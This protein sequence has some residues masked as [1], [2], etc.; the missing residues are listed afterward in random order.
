MTSFRADASGDPD[1]T[2]GQVRVGI[3]SA[4]NNAREVVTSG[5]VNKVPHADLRAAFRH[6]FRF[7]LDIPPGAIIK[8]GAYI[9]LTASHDKGPAHIPGSGTCM[10]RIQI[11]DASDAAPLGDTEHAITG[12]TYLSRVVDW[13]IE[14]DWGAGDRT[15]AQRA[16]NLSPLLQAIVDR[17]GFR[18]GNHV[19]FMLGAS[20][21][22]G[23]ERAVAAFGHPTHG[24]ATG[25][26]E[27]N[28]EWELRSAADPQPFELAGFGGNVTGGG[29]NPKHTF[30]VR[31]LQDSGEGSFR[32]AVMEA[33]SKAEDETKLISIEVEG[34]IPLKSLIPVSA[35]NITITGRHAPGPFAFVATTGWNNQL[36]TLQGQNQ[37]VEHC[38]FYRGTPSAGNNASA[39]VI[40]GDGV[41]MRFC[42]IAFSNDE[43]VT[44]WGGKNITL[45]YCFMFWPLNK[46]THKEKDKNAQPHGFGPVIGK[47]NGTHDARVTFDKCIMAYLAGERAPRVQQSHVEVKNTVVFHWESD[48][49]ASAWSLG[50]FDDIPIKGNIE[51]CI[52]LQA[53][54]APKDS[55]P[56]AIR[57]RSDPAHARKFHISKD[58]VWQK[59]NG[60]RVKAWFLLSGGKRS[61]CS[62]IP[63]D[64]GVPAGKEVRLLGVDELWAHLERLVGAY[65]PSRSWLDRQA[66][67]KVGRAARGV[68][69]SSA[70]IDSVFQTDDFNTP[71]NGGHPKADHTTAPLSDYD[72]G[73]GWQEALTGP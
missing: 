54:S 17:P 48:H 33:N 13:V 56:F 60:E 44:I 5:A 50:G 39:V 62:S 57:R 64:L 23:V 36:I 20:T 7:P 72:E 10:A 45:Q 47:N 16:P 31:S 42:S 35:D 34:I 69:V 15:E 14:D 18:R 58:S 41:A 40:T 61:E 24:G 3:S 6:A 53:G 30:A 8:P 55:V 52:Y 21:A 28:A 59:K 12:R 29:A 49:H 25:A 73:R 38:R 43:L 32:A 68:S 11:E 19:L 9:Q 22:S 2:S 37:L 66:L 67:V 63:V 27:L 65:L 46:N 4:E 51:G 26:A 71:E 1:E 70:I